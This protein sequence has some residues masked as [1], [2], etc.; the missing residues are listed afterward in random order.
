MPEPVNA[1]SRV[2]AIPGTRVVVQSSRADAGG[3]RSTAAALTRSA[4]AAHLGIIT[5]TPLSAV[6]VAKDCKACGSAP[7]SPR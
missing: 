7:S 6:Q 4:L 1:C 5:M 3:N 2:S